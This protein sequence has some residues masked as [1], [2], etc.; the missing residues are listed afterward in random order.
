M[1]QLSDQELAERTGLMQIVHQP[2]RGLN[3]VDRIYVS[4]PQYS[5]VRVMSSTVRS[6]HKAV[7]AYSEQHQDTG[8]K[9]H[10]R[11]TYRRK[12]PGQN[13]VFLQEA[14]SVNFGCDDPDIDT[15]TAFNKYYQV[16]IGLLNTYRYYRECTVVG[17]RAATPICSRSRIP[18]LQDA[19]PRPEASRL[20][21]NIKRPRN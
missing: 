14:A 17:L 16:A 4:C 13:A 2:T 6:D 5:I 19:G 9:I 10:I 18:D 11:R 8:I 3:I 12:S 20:Q 15:Q 7:I 21:Y 1:N